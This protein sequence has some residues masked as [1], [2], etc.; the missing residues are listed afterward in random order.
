MID[1]FR[2]SREK[3][4][5]ELSG[6]SGV[7]AEGRWHHEGVPCIYTLGSA[8]QCIVESPI[9]GIIAAAPERYR[10][11]RY[12]APDSILYIPESELKD[13]YFDNPRSF[14]SQDLGTR[15]LQ[16]MQALVIAFPSA[17]MQHEWIYLI[18]TRHPLM[19]EVQ[20]VQVY[21]PFRN[22][23]RRYSGQFP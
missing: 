15:L 3:R 22:S 23:A 2:L 9:A 10:I 19:Q 17:V 12:K 5:G 18:N 7:Q 20:V 21:P 6:E 16:E 8:A 13:F 14:E 11:T 4:A 1:L